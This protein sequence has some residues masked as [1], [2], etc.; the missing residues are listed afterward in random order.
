MIDRALETITRNAKQQARLIDDLLDVSAILGG[1]L[2]LDIRPVDLG[3]VLTAAVDSVR[4]AADAKKIELRTR[5][6]PPAGPMR[7]DPE[8]LQQVFW[9]LLS[10]AMKFTRPGGRVDLILEFAGAR[11]VV[12]VSDTGIGIPPDLL[13]VVFERFRQADSSM[14]RSQGGLGLGLAIVK[15]LVEMHGGRVEVASPGEGRGATLTVTLGSGALQLPARKLESV[16]PSSFARCDDI[17]ILLVDD[18]EDGRKLAQILLEQCG[19][20]VTTA[21]SGLE[22]LAAMQS[23]PPDIL[24]SDLAMPGM[25]GYAFIRR[26]RALPELRHIPAIALTAHARADVRVKALQAGFD[27]FVAKPIDP[28]ELLTVVV[29]ATRR[30]HPGAPPR[31][32]RRPRLLALILRVQGVDL[33]AQPIAADRLQ[34]SASTSARRAAIRADGDHVKVEPHLCMGCGACATV[35]PS[36]AMTYAYPVGARPRAGAVQVLVCARTRM[37]AGAMPALLLH[38]EDGRASNRPASRDAAAA[39]RRA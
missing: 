32:S 28:T 8:R 7:G 5:L 18:D 31:T 17:H 25:D 1:K 26:V 23:T 14:T 36:G 38:A 39:C 29:T 34:R 16:V 19:A 15:Q 33:R 24:I 22:G 27:T 6:A 10:N 4:P 37:P 13:P 20:H 30:R 11:A 21:G 35:C 3:L 9:N 12:R 2:R